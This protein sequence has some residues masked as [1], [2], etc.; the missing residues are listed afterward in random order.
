MTTTEPKDRITEDELQFISELYSNKQPVI[1]EALEQKKAKHKDMARALFYAWLQKKGKAKRDELIQQYELENIGP[2]YGMIAQGGEDA[3]PEVCKEFGASIATSLLYGYFLKQVLE[4]ENALDLFRHSVAYHSTREPLIV[5]KLPNPGPEDYP[6]PDHEKLL[7][8]I[9]WGLLAA[10]RR[11]LPGMHIYDPVLIECG[12]NF[13]GHSQG[14]LIVNL[15]KGDRISS[16]RIDIIEQLCKNYASILKILCQ[17]KIEFIPTVKTAGTIVRHEPGQRKYLEALG[18]PKNIRMRSLCLSLE[19]DNGIENAK[20]AVIIDDIIIYRQD[21]ME[22]SFSLKKLNKLSKNYEK[23][24]L[25]LELDKL[26]IFFPQDNELPPHY[27]ECTR[28]A[29]MFESGPEIIGKKHT[30]WQIKKIEFYKS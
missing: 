29:D 20:F 26:R 1:I 22:I 9:L 12:K 24:N 11:K 14:E 25:S 2:A 7:L 3:Y 28:V 15:P 16:K 13:T 23:T 21:R 30:S 10:I 6:Y 17:Y 18:F 5:V 8:S 19:K 27:T 4:R